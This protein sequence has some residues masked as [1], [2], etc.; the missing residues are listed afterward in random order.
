MVNA[1]SRSKQIEDTCPEER[2][3][4]VALGGRISQIRKKK[5]W[6]QAELASKLEVKRFKLRRWERGA[7]PP[8]HMLIL[9]SEVLETSLDV[10]L[11]GREA[12]RKESLTQDQ[13]KKAAQHL[14]QLA[15]LLQLRSREPRA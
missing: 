10:L 1:N 6:T 14:N 5:R 13:K 15:G 9:L 8:V 2:N 12:D 4:R 3:L 11:A 7:L